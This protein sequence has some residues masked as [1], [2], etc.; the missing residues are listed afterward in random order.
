MLWSASTC[1]LR[2]TSTV[3]RMCVYFTW[4]AHNSVLCILWKDY[5]VHVGSYLKG[6]WPVWLIKEH[7]KFW[8]GCSLLKWKAR[9][10]AV[11][12]VLQS[13]QSTEKIPGLRWHSAEWKVLQLGTSYFCSAK[14]KKHCTLKWNYLVWFA[15]L[16]A[17]KK[18]FNYITAWTSLYCERIAIKY[19]V[20]Y[21]S[22]HYMSSSRYLVE[23]CLIICT[24]ITSVEGRCSS[25]A[26]SLSIVRPPE[27]HITACI[28]VIRIVWVH[29][30]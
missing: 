26:R 27:H 4:S 9:W 7:R 3:S 19:A 13:L 14:D 12:N 16:K 15:H 2:F 24:L 6:F 10:G 11:N 22:G 23:I 17:V 21:F 28:V 8:K 5:F 1:L 18:L 20:P 29:V 30:I 25:S